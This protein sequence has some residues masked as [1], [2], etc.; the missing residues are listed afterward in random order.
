MENRERRSGGL[1]GEVLVIGIASVRNRPGR[2]FK[3]RCPYRLRSP[4][5]KNW[6]HQL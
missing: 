6:G 1:D 5:Q 4:T 3:A 2:H